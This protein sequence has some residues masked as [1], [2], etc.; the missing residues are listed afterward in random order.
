[1]KKRFDRVFVSTAIAGHGNEIAQIKLLIGPRGS[2]A[3][4]IFCE[5]MVA[6]GMG[7][8]SLLLSVGPGLRCLPNTLLVNHNP[9]LEPTQQVLFYD[10]VRA[11]LAQAVTRFALD[12]PLE[13]EELDDLFLIVSAYVHPYAAKRERVFVQNQQAFEQALQDLL[14]QSAGNSRDQHL[15]A[16]RTYLDKSFDDSGPQ[17]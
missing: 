1:M 5:R 15:A 4:H 14:K 13:R 7:V 2:H 3:E 11:A 8:E 9:L 17:D 10:P 12:G 16:L 6:S